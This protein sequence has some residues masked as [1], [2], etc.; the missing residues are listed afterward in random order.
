MFFRLSQPRAPVLLVL[1]VTEQSE[2]LDLPSPLSSTVPNRVYMWH[3]RA[4][5][6]TQ[7]H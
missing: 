1:F 6:L 4:Y 7:A 5:P 2:D 3:V